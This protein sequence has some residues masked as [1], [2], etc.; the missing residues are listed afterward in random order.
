MAYL[1]LRQVALEGET[2]PGDVTAVREAMGAWEGVAR[3]AMTPDEVNQYFASSVAVEDDA[4]PA[5]VTA[6]SD[7]C[8][9]NKPAA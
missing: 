6:T 9:A 4:T 8:L 2:P 1:S 7:W 3:A 5:V